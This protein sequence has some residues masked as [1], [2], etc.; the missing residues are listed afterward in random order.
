MADRLDPQTRQ[1]LKKLL[2]ELGPDTPILFFSNIFVIVLALVQ[3][4]SIV[5]LLWIYWWQSVIIGFFNWRRMKQLKKFSTEGLKVDGQYVKPTEKTKKNSAMFFLLH[6]GVFQ[7]FYLIFIL[8]LADSIPSDVLLSAAVGVGIFLFNHFFS[9]RHNLEKDLASTPNIGTMMFFP[10]FRV[11]P[12]HL[13]IFIGA[14]AGSGSQLTLFFFLLLK[15]GVDL[16]MHII[17]HVDWGKSYDP[18]AKGTKRATLKQ[19]M[20]LW[21]LMGW[22]AFLLLIAVTALIV[23]EMSR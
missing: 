20:M 14:W 13:I 11:I 12:M 21:F 16:V 1:E 23:N 9:Y 4:W 3:G 19:R 22:V 10:Y 2:G 15:T 8:T 5:P 6:Y 18:F 7:F 17:E